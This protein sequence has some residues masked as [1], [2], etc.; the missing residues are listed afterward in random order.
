MANIALIT[1]INSLIAQSIAVSLI[2]QDYKIIGQYNTVRPDFSNT[3]LEQCDLIHSHFIDY[4]SCIQFSNIIQQ[5]YS[6]IN[7][8]INCIGDFH[9]DKLN[10]SEE[11]IYNFDK[12]LHNNLNL[13]QYLLT[14]IL[15]IFTNKFTNNC[16][17]FSLASANQL[18]PKTHI[19]PYHIGKLGTELL[20]QT[21]AKHCIENNLNIRINC[22]ALGITETD[23]YIENKNSKYTVNLN[24]I[25]HTVEYILNNNSLNGQIIRLDNGW[26]L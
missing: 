3:V 15:P 17:L 7:L 12:I 24:N 18:T 1:G 2:Q 4:T 9:W 6:S 22:I 25:N 26:C 8:F 10:Y 5:N 13:T 23:K 16:I 19:L 20:T 14:S 11:Y 21:H